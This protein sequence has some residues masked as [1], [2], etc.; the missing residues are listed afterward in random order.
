MACSFD[1]TLFD[2]DAVGFNCSKSFLYIFGALFE[3][4]TFLSLFS[5][6]KMVQ[7]SI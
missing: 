2:D 4:A 6:V 1:D 7:H 5:F 3:T